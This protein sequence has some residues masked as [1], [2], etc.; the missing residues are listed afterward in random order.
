MGTQGRKEHFTEGV[1]VLNCLL[2]HQQ[3]DALSGLP[4]SLLSRIVGAD[5]D[6]PAGL[7][8]AVFS[9]HPA[10]FRFCCS[11]LFIHSV[12]CAAMTHAVKGSILASA[13]YQLC[14]LGQIT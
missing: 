10:S 11:H 7:R 5:W 12:P 3:P 2:H 14:G 4:Q 1:P 8:R 9:L 6:G 13:T